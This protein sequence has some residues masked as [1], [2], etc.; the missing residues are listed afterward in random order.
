MSQHAKQIAELAGAFDR[1]WYLQEYPEVAASGVEPVRH[2][3]DV[4][5]R[6]MRDP[7]P[8]FSTRWYLQTY[9]DVVGRGRNPFLHYVFHGIR[10][11]RRP[12][13]PRV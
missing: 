9:P 11:G 1:E 4:G 5:W 3:L 8:Y 12:A 2:Y 13:P 6:E 10:E 7:N